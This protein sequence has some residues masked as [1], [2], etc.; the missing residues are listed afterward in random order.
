MDVST[1]AKPS[2]KRRAILPFLFFVGGVGATGWTITQTEF[3]R[4]LFGSNAQLAGQS[5]LTPAPAATLAPAPT[6]PPSANEDAA[7]IAAL[8]SRLARVES[9]GPRGGGGGGTSARS[10]G[11]LL[12]FAARRALE[13]GLPLGSLEQ[14]LEATFGTTQQHMVAA[15]LAAARAPV[16]LAKL[17]ADLIP[18]S[19]RLS[20]SENQSLWTR[21]TGGLSGLVS[22][23]P[24]GSPPQ[25]PAM[26]AAQAKTAMKNGDIASALQAISRLP[27]RALAADW[28]AS[29]RRYV[30]AQRALS[31][32]EKSA[33]A[34]VMLPKPAVAPPAALES[35]SEPTTT[36]FG[37][38]ENLKPI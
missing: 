25:D 2:L 28:M 29:A 8:E 27:D 7:R 11:L 19:E 3:G 12:A 24:S 1:P 23:R 38:P 35:P 22:V 34:G 31:A 14:E 9:V 26:L 10:E 18:L 15:V 33:L 36:P 17:Q 16:T 6:A 5:D 32:L 37:T 21:F 20:G 4:S 30:E 13:L